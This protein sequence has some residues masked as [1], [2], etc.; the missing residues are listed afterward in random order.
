MS[1]EEIITNNTKLIYKVLKR[2][3]LYP[4]KD[5]FY[6][7]GMVGLVKGAKRYDS[8]L[9]YSMSTYLYKCIYNEILMSFRRVNSG[10]EIP[11]SAIVPL[12]TPIGDNLT[13]ADTIQAATDIENEIMKKDEIEILHNEISKL[14]NKER[15][16]INLYFGL[17]DCKRLKQKEIAK[18][19]GI[20]QAQVSRIKNLALKK[21]KKEMI[22]CRK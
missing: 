3:N 18:I 14:S 19:L 11:E 4:R 9:G 2:L 20:K 21:L 13:I 1:E 7:V 6:D 12:T 8:S 5:E 17:N 16:V 15:L 22:K 10:R